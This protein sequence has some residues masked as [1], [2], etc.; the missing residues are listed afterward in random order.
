MPPPSKHA[1][2]ASLV[3]GRGRCS[4]GLRLIPGFYILER[5]QLPSDL[6]GTTVRRAPREEELRNLRHGTDVDLV[7]FEMPLS[8]RSLWEL[9]DPS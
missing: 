2:P 7:L 6:G 3:W 8:V 9:E 5:L 1:L 4:D